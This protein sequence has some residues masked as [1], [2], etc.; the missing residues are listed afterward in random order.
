MNKK[1]IRI[2]VIVDLSAGSEHLV[3]F[4][5]YLSKMINAKIL[6][7]H[8]VIG[9]FPAM[10]EKEYRDKFYQAE[11]DDAKNK[12]SELVNGRVYGNEHF[13]VSEKPILSILSEMKSD[14]YSDWVVGGM[15]ESS[16]LKRILIGSTFI[17]IIDN[18]D[19]LTV[20][21]PISRPVTI[22][23][24]TL[25]AVTHEYVVNE[26][27]LTHVLSAFKDVIL[28]VQFFSIVKE[29]K[30]AELERSNLLNLQNKFSKYN[31]QTIL[32]KGTD[33]YKDLK[34]HL[35][36]SENTFLI[37]QEGSRSFI[38]DIF[39]RYMINE[40]IHTGNIKLIVLPNE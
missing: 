1:R 23:N 19:L 12:L 24:K 20:A 10:T 11:I 9:M 25:I 39:R 28:E 2:V 31:P 3:D 5:L 8:Q 37:L 32:L 34:K 16:L 7:V 15:K 30:D 33:K 4:G 13:V 35:E 17:K 27:Y 14:Y 29:E 21:V 38:D 26:S 18:S 40:I 6:F 22:P 36:N